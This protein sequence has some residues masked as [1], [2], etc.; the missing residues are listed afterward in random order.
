VPAYAVK[1]GE[2][3]NKMLALYF[4]RSR[5]H[6][7]NGSCWVAYTGNR[8]LGLLAQKGRNSLTPSPEYRACNPLPITASPNL[9]PESSS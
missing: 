1:H 5:T 9:Q 6:G 3:R 7:V 8:S 2:R 4:R